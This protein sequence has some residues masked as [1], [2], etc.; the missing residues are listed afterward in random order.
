M[1]AS[2]VDIQTKRFFPFRFELELIVTD[3][4]QIVYEIK[5]NVEYKPAEGSNMQFNFAEKHSA[6]QTKYYS[7]IE[8]NLKLAIPAYRYKEA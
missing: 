4:Q 1:N 3:T 5:T 2:I 6:I 7:A 8:A